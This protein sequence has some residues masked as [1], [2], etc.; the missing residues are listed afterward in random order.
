[1]TTIVLPLEISSPNRRYAPVNRCVYCGNDSAPL[2]SEHI[3]PLA[4]AG[5]AA[6]LPQ[7]SCLVCAEIT[8]KFEGNCTRGMLGNFRIAVG[9]PT[10]RPKDRPKSV[11]VKIGRIDRAGGAVEDV[12][13]IT[14]GRQEYPLMYP[15]F[16]FPRAGLLA[17]RDRNEEID[18][19]VSVHRLSDQM[20]EFAKK[21]GGAF[22]IDSTFYPV[23]FVRMIAKIAHSFCV[24][25]YGYGSFR[26]FLTDAIL[27][28][29]DQLSHNLFWVGCEEIIPKPRAELFSIGSDPFKMDSGECWL[30]TWLQLFPF[31]STP[32]YH[33]VVGDWL[34]QQQSGL[35][36]QAVS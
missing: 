28:R 14:L 11:D 6:I 33:V 12:Q 1:M 7:A 35:T 8:G 26:P 20:E 13:K 2:T 27:G 29:Y 32:A 30:V 4:L 3:I 15:T 23:D 16:T 10:R 5:N 19:Q 34:G 9:S 31:F 18:Y 25:T 21:H 22:E 24:A 17:G 36:P